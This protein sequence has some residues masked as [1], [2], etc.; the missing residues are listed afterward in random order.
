MNIVPTTDANGW[1]VYNFGTS[2]ICTKRVTFNQTVNSGSGVGVTLSSNNLPVGLSNVSGAR[3]SYSY[4]LT[5]G[6]AYQTVLVAE[7]QSNSTTINFTATKIVGSTS[8][9]TGYID[10]IFVI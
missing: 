7:M 9:S 5:N 1:S 6:N 3:M 2:K 8:N 4:A 10:V